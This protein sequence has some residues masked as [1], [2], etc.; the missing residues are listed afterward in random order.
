M[1]LEILVVSWWQEAI[2]WANVDIPSIS[3]DIHFRVILKLSFPK[4][5]LKFTHSKLWPYLPGDNELLN[6][7]CLLVFDEGFRSGFHSNNNM[8]ME[9]IITLVTQASHPHWFWPNAW[10]V[11]LWIHKL[12]LIYA[13]VYILRW[14]YIWACEVCINHTNVQN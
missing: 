5:C 4:L 13:K 12:V 9:C 6:V 8:S 10:Q 3:S 14:T 11:W 7:D 2:T 1:A